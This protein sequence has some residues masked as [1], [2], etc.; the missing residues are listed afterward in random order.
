MDGVYFYLTAVAA[1][2]VDKQIVEIAARKVLTESETPKAPQV[3]ASPGNDWLELNSSATYKC[4]AAVVITF[5][6]LNVLAQND[7][8]EDIRV[9]KTGRFL[10]FLVE[11]VLNWNKCFFSVLQLTAC[12]NRK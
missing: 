3:N 9:L 5:V 2:G 10:S 4:A 1:A 11:I 7:G 8:C 6:F 12:G